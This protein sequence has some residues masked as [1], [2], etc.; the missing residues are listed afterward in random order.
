VLVA[1]A[2]NRKRHYSPTSVGLSCVWSGQKSTKTTTCSKKRRFWLFFE[3]SISRTFSAKNYPH[4]NGSS[5]RKPRPTWLAT[6]QQTIT[7]RTPSPHRQKPAK[8]D[9]KKTSSAKAL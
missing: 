2:E 1:S 7:T 9:E 5:P 3:Q 6:Q 8:T 4:K